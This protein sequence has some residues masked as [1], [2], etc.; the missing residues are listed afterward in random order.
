MNKQLMMSRF[1]AALMALPLIACGNNST[2]SNPQPAAVPQPVPMQVSTM[3]T[4]CLRAAAQDTWWDMGQYK[5]QPYQS[6]AGGFT[7]QN[8]F[9]NGAICGCPAN[10]MPT[11]SAQGLVC[12]PMALMNGNVA[13]WSWSHGQNSGPGFQSNHG[14]INPYRHYYGGGGGARWG[15][16]GGPERSSG[17]LP[18]RGGQ[19]PPGYN[20]DLDGDECVIMHRFSPWVQGG[21]YGYAYAYTST[22]ASTGPSPAQAPSSAPFGPNNSCTI[23][24]VAQLCDV[25]PGQGP[26][27]GM[28]CQPLS[29]GSRKGIWVRQQ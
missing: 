23:T 7:P 22:T 9:P 26:V 18:A 8:A 12:V 10:T 5:V 15:R 20:I 21:I 19:C 16:R 2:N 4:Q 28:I 13:V 14:F 3:Q 11:C 6:P 29:P 1:L 25:I 27:N 17:R 24:S